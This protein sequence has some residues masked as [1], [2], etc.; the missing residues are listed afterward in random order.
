M[1][2][3]IIDILYSSTIRKKTKDSIRIE[4]VKKAVKKNKSLVV[5]DSM[6]TGYVYDPK[7]K[8]IEKFNG[9][10]TSI[11]ENMADNSCVIMIVDTLEYLNSNYLPKIIEQIIR[12]SGGNFFIVCIE[13]NSA[14][15]FYD[16]K[17][18]NLME[19]TYYLS[20]S[21]IRW[22]IPN[23]LQIQIQKIY[24]LIFK[25]LPYDL[26]SKIRSSF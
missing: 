9:N 3:I 17:I 23:N 14:R 20:D 26:I 16:Y 8:S 25:I 1:V 24:R 7:D 5:F 22:K 2:L 6:D 13:P 4:A 18:K 19:K 15:T 21:N 12:V 11:L 10:I